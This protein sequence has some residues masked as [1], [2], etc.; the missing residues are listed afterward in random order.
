[1]RRAGVDPIAAAASFL[2]G[3]LL[4]DGAMHE[5]AVPFLAG[6]AVLLWAWYHT[7]SRAAPRVQLLERPHDAE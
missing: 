5:N 2:G 4:I 6:A 1:M 3:W 7:L